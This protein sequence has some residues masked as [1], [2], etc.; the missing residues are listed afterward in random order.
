MAPTELS[1]DTETQ[2][3]VL[4]DF[5]GFLEIAMTERCTSRQSEELGAGSEELEGC[6]RQYQ[7]C[8]LGSFF[9]FFFFFYWK[10]ELIRT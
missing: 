6:R 4:M 10:L 8:E 5:F 3:W 7:S 2:Q 1:E 9:F